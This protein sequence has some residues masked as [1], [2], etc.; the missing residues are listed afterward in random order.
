LSGHAKIALQLSGQMNAPQ[1][2]GNIDLINGAYESLSTGALYHNIH[3]HLEGEGSK[4]ILKN[5]SAQDNK[6]GSITATGIVN[7][8]ASQHFPFEFQVHPSHIFILDSDYIDISA[9]GSL[10]L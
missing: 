3:A 8:D 7:L 2:R 6:N 1:I 5:F 9:S 4:I 10:S